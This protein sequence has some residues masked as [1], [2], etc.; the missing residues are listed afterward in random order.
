MPEGGGDGGGRDSGDGAS[1]GGG[2]GE[3]GGTGDE[4]GGGLLFFFFLWFFGT[5][6]LAILDQAGLPLRDPQ[7]P[8]PPECWD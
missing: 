7:L 3:G 8:L 1:G 2:D 6:A 5:V 4:V